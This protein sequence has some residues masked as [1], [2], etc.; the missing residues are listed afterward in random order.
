MVHP[1]FYDPRGLEW[2]RSFHGGLMVGCG[3]DNVG[4]PCV[5]QGE[6][7]GLHGRLS[8]TPAELLSYG[9]QWE[10]DEYTMWVEGQMRHFKVFGANLALRRKISARLG[11]DQLR[12][13]D[14]VANRGFASTPFQ[15]LYHC[16]FGFP[17]VSPDT[18]LWVETEHSEP[19]DD[20]AV[21]GFERHTRFEGPT[22]GYAEQVF[23]HRPVA[24]EDGYARAALVNV[25]M[26]FGAYVRFRV[27]ELP[28]LIEWKMMGQGTYVVGLEPANCGVGGRSEDRECGVLRT[29]EPGETLSLAVEIGVL[30][31]AAAIDAYAKG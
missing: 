20:E 29:L 25:E 24:G 31:D 1:A 3:P 9:G 13:E 6:E 5:D 10:G 11:G 8:N 4:V 17:V 30:P 21:K 7:L 23:L 18:E 19:R 27:A 28:H 12:I 16:N 2:L 26:A 22:P 15:I 14:T